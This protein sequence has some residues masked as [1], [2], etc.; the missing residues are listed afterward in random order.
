MA[1]WLKRVNW[2]SVAIVLT[3]TAGV[4]ALHQ[5]IGNEKIVAVVGL[6]AAVVLSQTDKMVRT[7]KRADDP[8]EAIP[9]P[10]GPVPP[11][12]DLPPAA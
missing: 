4:G 6:L 12:D 2:R 11:S 10:S 1:D 7:E 8:P 5:I 9:T 3:S